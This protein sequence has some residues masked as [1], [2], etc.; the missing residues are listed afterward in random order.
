M[1]IRLIKKIEGIVGI[2]TF[3]D[4]F[5]ICKSMDKGI[6]SIILENSLVSA[7]KAITNEDHSLYK[8]NDSLYSTD[9][10]FLKKIDPKSLDE[11]II[12][13]AYQGNPY[14]SSENLVYERVSCWRTDTD[15]VW[16]YDLH[17]KDLVV[18]NVYNGS[19]LGSINDCYFLYD[20]Q[21]KFVDHIEIFS[22]EIKWRL[23]FDENE[24]YS[25]AILKR[26]NILILPSTTLD[27]YGLIDRGYLR[28][29]D[30]DTGQVLWKDTAN[31]RLCQDVN[32]GLMYSFWGNLTIVDPEKGVIFNEKLIE[33][34][35]LDKLNPISR[36]CHLEW[37]YLYFCTDNHHTHPVHFGRVDVESKTLD[38]M[39]PSDIG[40]ENKFS[41]F[42]YHDQRFY[43]LGMDNVLHIYEINE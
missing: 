7:K 23:N 37:P 21:R 15:K 9:E 11:E 6:I 42:A 32:T 17:S 43:L 35:G 31:N 40:P 38:F 27:E 36:L 18:S 19:S 10:K 14:L 12:W 3:I 39:L 41:E 33:T 34:S 30:I 26:D 28:A 25:G 2:S 22:Q 24:K 1:K 20:R 16:F 13:S 8:R 4:D 29:I 5:L